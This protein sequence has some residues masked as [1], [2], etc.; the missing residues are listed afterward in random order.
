MFKYV[1]NICMHRGIMHMGF[2]DTSIKSAGGVEVYCCNGRI[3]AQIDRRT[4]TAKNARIITRL[5]GLFVLQ[6]L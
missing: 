1:A 2:G 3:D 4:N 6:F 5:L